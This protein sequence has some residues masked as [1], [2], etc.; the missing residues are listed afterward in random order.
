MKTLIWR[1]V[2]SGVFFGSGFI[3]DGS[4]VKLVLYAISYILAGGDVVKRAY[5]I[6]RDEKTYKKLLRGE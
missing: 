5:E 1:L 2:I 4:Q 3:V 6:I